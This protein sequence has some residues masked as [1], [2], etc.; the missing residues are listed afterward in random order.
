VDE[1]LA[2]GDAEFQKKA[3]GKMKDVSRGEGRTVLFVSH[4]MASIIDLCDR[5]VLLKD[6]CLESIGNT[7]EIVSR[8]LLKNNMYDH[9]KN[10]INKKRVKGN[11]DI[12]FEKYDIKDANN[13]S[14]THVISGQDV[15]FYIHFNVKKQKRYNNLNFSVAITDEYNNNL[16]HLSTN[17]EIE[18]EI[19]MQD[20]VQGGVVT[21]RIKNLPLPA[22][23]YHLNFFVSDYRT[24]FDRID[25]AGSLM[26]EDGNFFGTGK[27]KNKTTK[28]LHRSKWNFKYEYGAKLK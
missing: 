2:V 28:F 27:A 22:G 6:G 17:E 1:V 7:K 18:E 13:K 26:V 24:V 21:C 10:L 9:S 16:I 19:S 12:V 20:N 8:Y 23:S 11:E 15:G 25:Q 3:I 5:S 14:V 4:N